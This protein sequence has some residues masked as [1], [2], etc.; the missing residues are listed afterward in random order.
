MFFRKSLP[1]REKLLPFIV[2]WL[3]EVCVLD[4]PNM[5]RKRSAIISNRP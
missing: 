5:E 1:F 2:A 3:A 4:A